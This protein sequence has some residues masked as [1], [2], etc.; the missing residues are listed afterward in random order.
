MTVYSFLTLVQNNRENST[1]QKPAD[2]QENRSSK[3]YY[4]LHAAKCKIGIR[5]MHTPIL[6]LLFILFSFIFFENFSSTLLKFAQSDSFLVTLILYMQW[7]R[8]RYLRHNFTR[9]CATLSP[10]VTTQN[11]KAKSGILSMTRPTSKKK[12]GSNDRTYDDRA[13]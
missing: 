10:L 11:C 3:V 9:I 12:S 13:N 1:Q 2:G 4:G 6:F 8:S 7:G 5:L